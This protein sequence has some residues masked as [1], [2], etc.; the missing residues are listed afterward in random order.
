VVDNILRSGMAE[1]VT[2]SVKAEKRSGGSRGPQWIFRYGMV[3]GLLALIVVTTALDPSFLQTNNLLNLLRQ[4]APPGLMAVGMTFVI[5]SG[6]FDL[7]VGG[8]YAAAAVLSAALALIMPIPAAVALAVLMG[9]GIGLVNGAVITRLE[10]NP[11]VATLGMGFIVTGL[12]EVISNAHPIM[13]EDPAFQIL[14]GGDLLGIP[15]PGI[16]L[17]IALLI[18]GVVLARSVYGRYVYAIGGGDEASRLTG[19]R[20]RSVRTLAYVITGALAALA[21]CVIASQLGEGQGDI[22]INVELGVITIVIVGGNAVSGGEGAMWR[23][24][25]GIGILAILGNAFD[26]LQVSTFWQEVIEGC[27][28]IAALAIDSYGKRRG[29]R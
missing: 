14:G 15:I 26:H 24:A 8:T 29:Q 20:T 3:L 22:G 17:I 18:G 27:I 23:T 5:I 21:G 2:T 9:A 13:V 4:W 28:I 10:V 12:T 7:S 11:F 25:T 19:L 6:G 1:T 16:L